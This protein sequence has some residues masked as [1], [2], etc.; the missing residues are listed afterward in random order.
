MSREINWGAIG[1]I[2]GVVGAIAT[3]V[4]IFHYSGGSASPTISPSASISSKTG[5]PTPTIS[6]PTPS[7]TSPP[8]VPIR[9]HGLLI[10]AN[11]CSDLYDLDSTNKSWGEGTTEV[12]DGEFE[13]YCGSEILMTYFAS[14]KVVPSNSKVM[15]ST[16]EGTGFGG[17]GT[18]IQYSDLQKG[19][20]LCFKT[21]DGRLSLLKVKSVSDSSLTFVVTTWQPTGQ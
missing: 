18:T 4:T 14:Y 15:F 7:F 13:S 19:E 21:S 6:S 2:A 5:S 1:A 10:V 16:C 12:F 3:V 20:E 9:N 8:G 17:Q 11:S